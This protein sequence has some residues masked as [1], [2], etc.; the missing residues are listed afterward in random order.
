[1]FSRNKTREL[2]SGG[3]VLIVLSLIVAN[4]TNLAI[5]FVIPRLLPSAEYVSFSVFWSSGQLF[6][7]LIFEWLRLGVM[8]YSVDSSQ[9][10]VDG[11]NAAIRFS[12]ALSFLISAVVGVFLLLVSRH[13]G[14]YFWLGIILIYACVQGGFDASQAS[15]RARLKNV[16]FSMSWMVRS[17]VSFFLTVGL[18]WYWGSALYAAIGLCLSYL[19]VF[20]VSDFKLSLKFPQRADVRFLFRYGAMGAVGGIVLFSI[21]VLCRHILAT[22]LEPS[23]SAGAILAIDLS[24]KVLIVFAVALNLVLLQPAIRRAAESADCAKR[25]QQNHFLRIVAILPPFAIALAFLTSAVDTFFVPP[26][27]VDGYRQSVYI[28]IISALLICIK[29]FG[30]DAIFIISGRTSY[31]AYSSLAGLFIAVTGWALVPNYT[32]DYGTHILYVL[33]AS[34]LVS[35]GTALYFAVSSLNLTFSWEAVTVIGGATFLG[36]FTVYLASEASGALVMACG[37]LTMILFGILYFYLDIVGLRA[38]VR[39]ILSRGL[40]SSL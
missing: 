8:R 24:Q 32:A 36:F 10:G 4:L 28:A 39:R 3:G 40:R 29:S 23:V 12:Y 31:A 17:F 22:G 5:Q 27:F 9:Q 1:M 15:L 13:D 25:E 26:D 19:I 11:F 16:R 33:L 18:A 14:Y 21:P 34:A 6:A 30:V 20:V 38:I 35:L 37:F 2:L 7:A